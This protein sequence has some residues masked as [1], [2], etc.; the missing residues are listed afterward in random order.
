MGK[1]EIMKNSS[2]YR[3]LYLLNLLSQKDCSKNEIIEEF[4]KIGEKITKPS[5]NSYIKKLEEN[6]FKIEIL[7]NKNSNIY[8]LK[9]KNVPLELEE[10]ELRCL[11]DIKKVLA[12]QKDYNK[13]RNFIRILYKF[14]LN[15]KNENQASRFFD[16]DYYSKINWRLV[17]ELEKHCKNKDLIEIDYVLHSGETKKISLYENQIKISDW[18]TRLY[19]WGVFK[20]S[21]QLS[22]LP[23]DR[24]LM[25]NKVK[26]GQNVLNFYN[27]K[28]TYTIS[29]SLFEDIEL[30]KDEKLIELT[31]KYAT[32]QRTIN[33][34]FYLLQRLMSFCPDL[35][36]ISDEKIK[37][38]IKE[39]LNNL[40]LSYEGEY[41]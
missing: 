32:I 11:E 4:S 18:S 1:R 20:G 6:N 25:I 24:I 40:K 21:N 12:A 27:K 26:K 37:N 19:L 23:I 16:F 5:I 8:R 41:E 17:L 30:D 29:K 14:V 13:I 2:T 10:S 35:F 31:D 34:E 7:N 3:V 28:I 36:Y 9:Q 39:K 38:S 22:Y 15:I 33:D